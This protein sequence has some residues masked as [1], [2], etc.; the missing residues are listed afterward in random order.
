MRR[1][2]RLGFAFGLASVACATEPLPAEPE[3]EEPT[4]AA[5]VRCATPVG[6]SGRPTTI[7]A[8]I[9]LVN[10]LPPPVDVAC[11]L[12]A[13]ERPLPVQATS[14]AVSAQP[15]RGPDSPRVFI[16]TPPLIISVATEGVGASLVE[17]A[18]F[19]SLTT[20]IKAEIALPFENELPLAA[21]FD[22]IRTERGTTCGGCHRGEVPVEDRPYPG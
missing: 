4:L 10:A 19:T 15:A 7:A 18:E 1:G 22:H 21:A 17:F 12:E 9:E 13:L 20:S 5:S 14:S 11:F 16:I 3:E 8:A 6:M 2:W